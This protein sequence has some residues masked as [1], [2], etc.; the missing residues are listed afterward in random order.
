[1]KATRLKLVDFNIPFF[2]HGIDIFPD[3]DGA[4][5][6]QAVNHLGSEEYVAAV[7]KT[8]FAGDRTR[9][10][11]EIFHHVLGSGEAKH[12]R[13]IRHPLIRTPND[14]LATGPTS[15]FV[16][17]DHKYKKGFLRELEDLG[18]KR[19]AGWTET[20]H[21]IA[22]ESATT[23]EDAVDA[24]V[25]IS[26]MHN[27]NGI[28]RTAVPGQYIINS[29]AGGVSTV[30]QQDGRKLNEIGQI[31][32]HTTLDNPSY[33]EDPFVEETGSDASGIINGGLSQAGALVIAH[34]PTKASGIV[35][36]AKP[37]ATGW[38]KPEPIFQDDASLIKMITTA[39]M[40]AI[41]PKQ[42]KGRKQGWLFVTSIIAK[43]VVAVRV[44]L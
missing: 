4:L 5:Y 40:V 10:Q 16:T 3:G 39:V 9:S 19:T 37:T 31:P 32:H 1:M 33:F 18:G 24:V 17:N 23:P 34:D 6:I 12:V 44:D 36:H 2:T 41:D 42:N 43:A 29:A 8:A 25:A 7:N 21:V 22:S 27:N 26:G 38:S 15:F 13:S 20:L 14:I 30:V 11:I 28:G 35:W